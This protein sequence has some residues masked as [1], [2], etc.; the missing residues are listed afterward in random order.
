MFLDDYKS[1]GLAVNY[2]DLVAMSEYNTTHY[3]SSEKTTQY[4]GG[5]IEEEELTR[6]DK[7]EPQVTTKFKDAD[8]E[9]DELKIDGFDAVNFSDKQDEK[10]KQKLDLI[11]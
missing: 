7:L 10:E 8:D 4:Q 3:K 1:Q 6:I 2:I 11:N 5:V 9:F